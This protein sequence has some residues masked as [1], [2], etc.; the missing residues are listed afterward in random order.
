MGEKKGSSSKSMEVL[1]DA[2]EVLKV[3]ENQEFIAMRA[4]K[5]V[6]PGPSTT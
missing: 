1:V 4:T 3:I 2:E 6:W 5:K